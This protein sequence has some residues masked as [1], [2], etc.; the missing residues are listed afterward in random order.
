M[1]YRMVAAFVVGA[2]Y[3]G[4]AS[5][6]ATVLIGTN[7]S[8]RYLD[9]GMDQGTLWRD[10]N[11]D[12]TAWPVGQASLGFGDPAT[13]TINGGPVSNR[14][15]TIYFRTTFN[16]VNPVQFGS[17]S[18]R[19]LRDDGAVVY[20]NGAEIL[21][22][23][24]PGG[25]ITYNTFA[26]SAVTGADE[27]TFFSSTVSAAG[28]VSGPN[29]LAV[30]V[31][32]WGNT[33][34]D[35]SFNLELIGDAPSPPGIRV[36]SYVEDQGA[37]LAFD[38]TT[39]NLIRID[40]SNDGVTWSPIYAATNTGS[41]LFY[42]DATG[43]ASRAYRAVDVESGLCSS[44]AVA[45]LRRLLSPGFNMVAH[46]YR[47]TNNAIWIALPAFVAGGTVYKMSADG[48]FAANNFLTGWSDT[49][50]SLL[51]G[52]GAFFRNPNNVGTTITLKGEIIQGSAINNLPA[53]FSICSSIVPI[54]GSIQSTLLFPVVNNTEIFRFSPA[55]G[56]YLVDIYT[57]GVWEGDSGGEPVINVGQAFWVNRPSAATWTRLFDV[58]GAG[59]SLTVTQIPGTSTVAQVNFFTYNTTAGQGRV[60]QPDGITPLTNGFSAQLYASLTANEANVSPVGTPVLFRSGANGY[61]RGDTVGIPGAANQTVYLQLRV[62][63][64]ARGASY[65]AALSNGTAHG[66][67]ALF[68]ALAGTGL[69][70]PGDA[71]SF[72]SFSIQSPPL[73]L[74]QPQN[75]TV[76]EGGTTSFSVMASGWMLSYRWFFN[77]AALLGATNSSRTIPSAQC[78]QAGN[79][80]VMVSNAF[81]VVTS[82][83]ATLTVRDTTP[84]Q[85]TCPQNIT[86][87]ISGGSVSILY[88]PMATD[89]CDASLLISCAPPSGS[90]FPPGT[91]SVICQARDDATNI[92]SCMFSVTVVGNSDTDG[93]GMPDVWEQTYGF[94]PNNAADASGDADGDG[95][96][97]VDEY[98]ADTGPLDA[99]SYLALDSVTRS[100]GSVSLAFASRTGIT[101]RV[102]YKN[103]LSDTTWT[104]LSQVLGSGA[105]L[106]VSDNTASVPSRYY[107]VG[108]SR[109]GGPPGVYSVNSVGYV[110]INILQGSNS[111]TRPLLA[112]ANNTIEFLMPNVPP[113]TCI[114]KWIPAMQQYTI[115][116]FDDSDLVWF[117]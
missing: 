2:L 25:T 49:N 78:A 41:T 75:A 47:D 31:H 37:N 98:R 36:L 65:E 18:V 86:T 22:S 101:Y 61:V 19:L 53:G 109:S 15:S 34:T 28:I 74:A 91:T 16:V 73:I 113:G 110:D 114:Y 30:E 108:A 68:P 52:E 12:D 96:T 33:S 39:G 117:P 103:V 9:S 106:V 59:P 55:T 20:L 48:K 35:L 72:A 14:F 13:T 67:S 21:R 93:D 80:F 66:E 17:L 8:W 43:A 27:T 90:L 57:D 85:I 89:S 4:A 32:Q 5:H 40:A 23:N 83:V 1:K 26:S 38:G 94:D 88:S 87:N 29:L 45:Y 105:V 63:E 56:S 111:I 84:P 77:G 46:P 79:Y 62:W 116:C 11:Y 82:E 76:N 64:T 42:T 10:T 99:N 54:S 115:T 95:M 3:I 70:L 60:F 50:M 6:A 92:S 107:R 81:G 97:N 71:N 104:L 100:S 51:P 112:T 69:T 24:M 7:A 58:C 44:N 102:D